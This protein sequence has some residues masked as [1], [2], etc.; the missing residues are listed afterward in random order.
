MFYLYWFDFYRPLCRFSSRLWLARPSPS[1]S[2]LLTLSKMSR[3]RSKTRREFLQINNVWSLLAN[4]WKMAKHCRITISKKI[5]LFIWCWDFMVVSLNQ[6]W[7]F[8]PKNTILT[9]WFAENVMLVFIP[10]PPIVVRRNAD[11]PPT[12]DP[13]RSWS[14]LYIFFS[15]NH[16]SRKFSCKFSCKCDNKS[17]GFLMSKNIKKMSHFIPWRLGIGKLF[18][19]VRH[20]RQAKDNIFFSIKRLKP[21]FLRTNFCD[22]QC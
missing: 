15:R 7:D 3:L 5:L 16:F 14:N 18:Y 12:S 6:P 13:R 9:K 10:E 19:R 1:R 22:N 17:R 21:F 2:N 11:T 20:K 8:W 4:N